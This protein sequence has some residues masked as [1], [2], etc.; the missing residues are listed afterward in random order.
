MCSSGKWFVG[1]GGPRPR[2]GAEREREREALRS[3]H[4]GASCEGY[5]ERRALHGNL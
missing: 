1:A 2:A 3:I 4:S 5:R